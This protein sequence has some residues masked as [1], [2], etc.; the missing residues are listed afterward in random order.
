MASKKL[1]IKDTEQYDRLKISVQNFAP[2][3]NYIDQSNLRRAT[4]ISINT[5]LTLYCCSQ[6]KE[7]SLL[8]E[9]AQRE[10]KEIENLSD[11]RIVKR[12]DSYEQY[13]KDSGYAERTVRDRVKTV[14]SFYRRENVTVPPRDLRPLINP[15]LREEIKNSEIF[16][17]FVAERNLTNKG[18]IGGYLTILTGY[19]DYYSMSLEELIE[20][21]EQEEEKGVRLGKRK[22]KKRLI[23]YRNHLFKKGFSN[24]TVRSK[25]SNLVYFYVCVD[26][27]VPPLPKTSV[28]YDRGISFDEVPK[29]EHVKKAI[30]TITS[31]KNRALFF[32][33][34]TSLSGS[35]EAREFTVEEY[36]RGVKGFPDNKD[37]SDIDIYQVL[38]EVEKEINEAIETPQN[39]NESIIPVFH[40]VR[41]KKKRDYFTCITP[42]ANQYIINYL[43][44]REGLTLEDKVFDYSRKSL[45]N[46]FQSVNDKNNWGWVNRN[47][48]RFFTSHQLRRLGA[49]LIEDERLV[50]QISGRKFDATTEAY[51]KRDKT[52]IRKEYFKWLD[53]LTIYQ[54]YRVNFMTDEKYARFTEELQ[55]ERKKNEKLKEQHKKEIDALQKQMQEA[56]N[57]ILMLK[58]VS[59]SRTNLPFHEIQDAIV[60]YLERIGEFSNERASLLN[61]MVYD[62][63]RKHPN[64]YEDSPDYLYKLIRELDV[65]IEL[66]NNDIFQQHVDLAQKVNYEM[67]HP[68]YVMLLDELMD[69]IQENSGVMKRIGHLDVNK[70][71][72]VAEEYLTNHGI[73]EN[74]SISEDEYSNIDWDADTIELPNFELNTED[75]KETLAGK[76]LL[77]YLSK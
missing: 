11:R 60:A 1:K 63:V 25:M 30:E 8:L 49:N 14:R 34:M 76:I 21:A 71:E 77:E 45:I 9:E 23:E 52:K 62:Y 4:R 68:A 19:C 40:F 38:D 26:I 44:T 36:I 24:K 32:F 15:E 42:E 29:K 59:E 3:V 54:K 35:A 50:N 47:R 66:S 10:E 48:Q 33:C 31:I 13:L 46:A 73:I 2:L 5:H 41:V 67:V 16:N 70:F 65:K 7:L 57:D 12:L 37:I 64:E 39:Q 18:T 51:F 53:E 72:Y 55:A 61:L 43:K 58:Q 56:K 22:V 28:P 69:I 20:E 75:D 27:E 74:I 17:D 6:D